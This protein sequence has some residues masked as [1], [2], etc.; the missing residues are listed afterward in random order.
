[1]PIGEK[2]K[3]LREAK[4]ITQYELSFEIGIDR[5]NINRIETGETKQPRWDSVIR[6]AE[7]FEVSIN[8]LIL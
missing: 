5:S 2:L 6:K 1:M 3:Q 7:Y 8:W 4:N